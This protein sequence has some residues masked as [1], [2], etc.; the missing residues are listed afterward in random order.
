[1]NFEEYIKE[2]KKEF[3]E[4]VNNICTELRIEA[5]W[6][7]FTMWFESRL[8]A[9]AINPKSMAAGLIQFMPN[10]A[11]ELGTSTEGLLR[12]SNVEQLDYVYKYLKPYKGRMKTWVDVYLA[13]FYPAAMG[14][15][16][17]YVIKS[18]LVA[19]Q[20]QIFDLNKDL[21]ISVSE[22]KKVLQEHI[23]KEYRYLFQ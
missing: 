9:N 1:M 23:P 5:N 19:K 18:D 11:K 17:D 22:I 12:M 21:D 6:L 16:D 8:K 13:V 14:K 10:T 15:G 7:M 4:K 20:N 2:N 3:T